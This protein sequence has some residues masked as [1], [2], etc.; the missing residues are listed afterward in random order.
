MLL[1]PLSLVRVSSSLAFLRSVGFITFPVF[2]CNA[3]ID[4]FKYPLDLKSH[5]VS[6]QCWF[7]NSPFFTRFALSCDV[8]PFISCSKEQETLLLHLSSRF[9]S[10]FAVFNNFG[11]VNSEIRS[12]FVLGDL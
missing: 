4:H 1:L 12:H 3:D 11:I 5:H 7:T 6:S 2:H 10:A 8:P 9:V